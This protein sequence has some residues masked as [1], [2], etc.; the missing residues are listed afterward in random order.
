[1]P[2]DTT[3]RAFLDVERSVT[4]RRWTGP[5][6]GVARMAEALAQGTGLPD[7]VCGVLASRGVEPA[8]ATAY[9]A[10]KLRDLMPDPR[11]M[12]D[13]ERAA[14][15]LV[16]AAREGQRV[17]VFADYDV[18]GATSAA[19]L[20]DWLAA[21]G[22][23]ATLYVPDRI[24][25]GYGP[26]APAIA[27]L[28][29]VHDLLVCVD[30]GTVAHE[31]LA[32]SSCD[33]V[34]L[35]HHLGGETLPGVHAVVNPNR[36]D[37]EGALGHLCAAGVVFL[38]LVEA[39]RQMREAGAEPP[40][41]TPSLDLVALAT[42]ADVAPL[43]GVNRAFVRAGL[44]VMRARRR[45]GLV[46]LA[47]AARL[48]GPPSSHHLG[49]VLGPRIN[50]GGRVGRA[51][52][53]ARLLVCR[54]PA[55]AGALAA[56]LEE[57]NAERRAV[58]ARVRDAALAEAEGRSPV[59]WA[60]GAGWHPGVVGIVAGR[61]ARLTGRP[62]VIL[63]LEG[64]VAKGSGRSVP[65]VDLGRAVQRLVRE[66]LLIAGGGH[67]MAAG[68]SAREERLPEAM[69]RLGELLARQGA[70]G[71]GPRDLALDGLLMPGA[72]TVEL[73][74]ALEAAGPYG[75][76]SPAPR[77]ACP[78]V[79]VHHVRRMGESHLKVRFSDGMGPQREA[80]AFGAYD[81]PLGAAVENHGGARLHLA[82]R[83][84]INHWRGRTGV[85][86]RLSDA[87]PA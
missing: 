13:V 26:N 4:G 5:A 58:E 54:D 28:S 68:L 51:D 48:D 43:R 34:V 65:G 46:A 24:A 73:C 85:Q 61:V 72:A 36:Q 70:G 75:E 77:F 10:P 18:D 84:E 63:G 33:V 12:R 69:E 9:L 8:S 59:A 2:H 82:G 41:L 76:G 52:L 20:I 60:A 44:Q 74:E 17:A 40:D 83:V 42:V 32:A 45:P 50:A 64:G 86:L 67:E 6:A 30:C 80:V 27:R 15:R 55:E 39:N 1:M 35:D 31:A 57:V 71:G 3:A 21:Q 87:A 66:G 78:G 7:P 16:H 62:A 19:L 37:E 11:A 25:E 56:R 14:E 29:A 47:E 49:F 38:T 79:L 23:A 22:R 81:G 53:G